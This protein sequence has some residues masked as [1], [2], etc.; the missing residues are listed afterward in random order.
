MSRF[1]L[2]LMS[3]QK[4]LI[5]GLAKKQDFFYYFGVS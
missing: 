3:L 5:T 4:G 2:H 1:L